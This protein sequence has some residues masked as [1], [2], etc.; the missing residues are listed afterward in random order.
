MY[1]PNFT[2]KNSP[3]ISSFPY[4]D[5]TPPPPPPNINIR[6]LSGEGNGAPGQWA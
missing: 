5:G 3:F 2:P 4:W 1:V 6:K